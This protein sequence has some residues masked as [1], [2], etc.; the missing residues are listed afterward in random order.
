M[1]DLQAL[2]CPNCGAALTAT[3]DE[4]EIK[5]QYC[6]TLVVAPN[7]HPAP[8]FVMPQQVIITAPISS[9]SASSASRAGCILPIVIFGVILA[10]TGVIIAAVAAVVI[11]IAATVWL[12]TLRS[13][14]PSGTATTNGTAPAQ[15]ALLT[16]A[17]LASFWAEHYPRIKSE[18]QRKYPKHEWR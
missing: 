16:T 15:D 2:T 4:T 14:A 18:M 6:G 8:Q 13:T 11:L 12:L 1:P 10:V 9:Y 17:D 5:C 3:G 7:Q